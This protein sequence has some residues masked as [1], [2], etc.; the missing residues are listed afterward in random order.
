VATDAI[1]KRIM[2]KTI[3][4]CLILIVFAL[5][6]CGYSLGE[7]NIVVQYLDKPLTFRVQSKPYFQ[8]KY[9]STHVYITCIGFINEDLEIIVD[10]SI[11]G[12]E[13][14][15]FKIFLKKGVIN[16]DKNWPI[17]FTNEAPVLI[18]LKPNKRLKGKL[19]IWVFRDI[20]YF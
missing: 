17:G 15:N 19:K 13:R 9:P 14:I 20:S 1:I 18:T 2:K 12:A 16:L 10:N 4:Y 11:L 8:S 6:A 7:P 3:N 5:T